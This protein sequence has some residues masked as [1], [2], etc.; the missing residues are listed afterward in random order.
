MISLIFKHSPSYSFKHKCQPD[1]HF[2]YSCQYSSSSSFQHLKPG[3]VLL[4]VRPIWV[5]VSGLLFPSSFHSELASVRNN[6][7][8]LWGDLSLE[9]LSTRTLDGFSGYHLVSL[10]PL[11]SLWMIQLTSVPFLLYVYLPPIPFLLKC[12]FHESRDLFFYV[13]HLYIPRVQKNAWHSY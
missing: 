2:I 6:Q 8:G 10:I 11:L 4:F 9:A 13:A 12:K 3:T 1:T 7:Y 5:G